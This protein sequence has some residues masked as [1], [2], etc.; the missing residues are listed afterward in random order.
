M[1][2]DEALAVFALARDSKL[3]GTEAA[4]WM[5][6][7]SPM[8]AELVD[9]AR[10]LAGHGEHEKAVELAANTWRLFLMLSDNG[11]GRAMLAAA[12]ATENPRPTSAR[13]FALYGDG[14]LAFREG[15]QP[16]SRRRNDEALATARTVG[17]RQAEALALVGLSRVALR[18]GDYSAR[19]IPG[20]CSAR[21]RW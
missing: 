7:L 9:C 16:D 4:S 17:D 3:S 18:D 14:A 13:A 10:V 5:E 12:L 1:T 8:R 20:R 15:N 2:Y 21:A 11:Q 6:R 19:T